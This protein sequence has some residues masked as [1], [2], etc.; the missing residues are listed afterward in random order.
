[1]TDFC[2]E[3]LGNESKGRDFSN[4]HAKGEKA[5]V[6]CNEEVPVMDIEIEVWT[7]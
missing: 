4:L 5:G 6:A 1:M 7:A 2:T 3:T